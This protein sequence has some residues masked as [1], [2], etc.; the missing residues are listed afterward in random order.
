MYNRHYKPKS[1]SASNYPA[2]YDISST[3]SCSQQRSW[4][5]DLSSD[6]DDMPKLSNSEFKDKNE[7]TLPQ[8]QLLYR[9]NTEM[10]HSLFSLPSYPLWVLPYGMWLIVSANHRKLSLFH[11]FLTMKRRVETFINRILKHF[12]P[13]FFFSSFLHS[14]IS[15]TY[16]L[17]FFIFQ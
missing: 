12:I 9:L 7:Q 13:C 10:L 16:P 17:S 2:K 11:L 1:P 8:T 5:S 3:F 15:F 14:T 6:S 4:F